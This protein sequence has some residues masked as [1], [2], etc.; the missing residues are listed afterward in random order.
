MGDSKSTSKIKN[1]FKDIATIISWVVFLLLIVIGAILVYYVIAVNIYAKKG[2]SFEPPFA[3]YTIISPSMEP[4]IKVY[5]VIIDVPVKKPEDIKKGDII[6]FIS[7]ST[8]SAGMTVTHR[9]VD[10]IEEDGQFKY[11]TRGD[12]N[13]SADSGL[14]E[15]SNVKGKTIGKI[16]QLG[17]IQF[18]LGTKGGWFFAILI[19]ALGI[20]IYDVLKLLKIVGTEGKLNK[21]VEEEKNHKDDKVEITSDSKNIFSELESSP[22]I[23]D[24]IVEEDKLDITT[25]QI[26]PREI[27]N[28]ETSNQPDKLSEV[29]VAP[30]NIFEELNEKPLINEKLIQP[31][32]DIPNNE[33]SPSDEEEVPTDIEMPKVKDDFED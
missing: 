2:D 6:T 17:R 9:V 14:A 28:Q 11:K 8:I 10:I 18:F 26:T 21:I 12:N 27:I 33:E 22:L 25:S 5:D 29:E 15:Y 30:Q 7:T 31:E 1:I 24:P 3:L 16:P 23:S 13:Q 32:E 20:I 19:P 4:K